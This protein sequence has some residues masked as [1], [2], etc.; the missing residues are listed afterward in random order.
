M[1][2]WALTAPELKAVDPHMPLQASYPALT[3]AAQDGLAVSG[4]N[5]PL[6]VV[7][8]VVSILGYALVNSI[9]IAIIAASINA[10]ETRV[11]RDAGPTG[12]KSRWKDTARREATR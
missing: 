6:I 8:L 1:T 12:P 11:A 5:V 9:E 4:L 2:L 10:L 3:L 7:I